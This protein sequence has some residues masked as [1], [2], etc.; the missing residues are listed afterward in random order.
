[1]GC[2]QGL[3][4]PRR[5]PRPGRPC[6]PQSLP[7][8]TTQL[9]SPEGASHPGGPRANV[10]R[11]QCVR[12]SVPNRDPTVAFPAEEGAPSTASLTPLPQEPPLGPSAHPGRKSP[13]WGGPGLGEVTFRAKDLHQ[14]LLLGEGKTVI[15][16]QSE[17]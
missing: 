14:R 3:P 9:S 11:A 13:S 17:G 6:R 4:V 2:T 16:G 12:P 1:M 5:P 8:A 7:G 10:D 15:L